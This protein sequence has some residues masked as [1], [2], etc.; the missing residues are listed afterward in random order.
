MSR[1]T[2]D[3]KLSYENTIF[4]SINNQIAYGGDINYNN[5]TGGESIYGLTFDDEN[6]NLRHVKKYLLSMTNQGP[7]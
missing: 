6:F 1:I 7:N 2:P 4:Y 3:R 5:G